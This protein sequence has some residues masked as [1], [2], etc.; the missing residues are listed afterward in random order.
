VTA[1]PRG[2]RLHWRWSRPASWQVTLAAAL[3]AL[4]FLIAVQFQ[5]EAPRSRYSTQERPPLVETAL[6][7]SARQQALKDDIVALRSQIQQLEKNVSADDATLAGLNDELVQAR[8][9]A[10]LIELSG[11]GVALQLDDAHGPLPPD[12]SAADYRV[13]AEDLRDL[14]AALWLSGA[15]AIAINGERVSV[16]TSV[17]DIGGTVLVNSAYLAPPYVVRAI[18][19]G[20]LYDRLIASDG[21]RQLLDGGMQPFG[22]DLRAGPLDDVDVPAYSGNVRLVEARPEASPSPTL[23]PGAAP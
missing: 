8:I 15:E 10:G 13:Q 4:G 19:G 12:A 20:D 3:L 17:S 1:V 9:A 14:L 16:T 22:L 23:P 5:S 7:L 18:G 21:L 11:P 6:E 2:P